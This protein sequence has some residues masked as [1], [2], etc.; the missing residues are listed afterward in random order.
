MLIKEITKLNQ[1]LKG[2]TKQSKLLSKYID[3]SFNEFI[4]WMKYQLEPNMTFENYG[5][6]W[7]IDHVKPCSSFDFTK[8]NEIMDCMSWKNLRP[9][10]KQEN[11]KK[12]DKIDNEL[13]LNHANKV[14]NYIKN[15]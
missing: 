14:N 8:D 1:I 6:E 15:L 2:K 7:H 9:C 11:L 3:C 4:N 5:S 12:S 13:I 10:W